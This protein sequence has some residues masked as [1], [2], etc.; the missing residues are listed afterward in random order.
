VPSR[1]RKARGGAQI[2][3]PV[4]EAKKETPGERINRERGM[5]PPVIGGGSQV[6]D[7]QREKKEEWISPRTYAQF[8]KMVGTF[9]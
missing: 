6:E 8:Q 3:P 5:L 9:L 2:G 4:E 7:E 1:G